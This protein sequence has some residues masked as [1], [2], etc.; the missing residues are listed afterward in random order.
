MGTPVQPDP[1]PVCGSDCDVCTPDPLASG[2]TPTSI[3]A[4]FHDV[5]P[6][7]PAH[8][9]PNDI[10][11]SL[12][13]SEPAPCIWQGDLNFGGC[14]WRAQYHAL[15]QLFWLLDTTC[16]TVPHFTTTAP[17]CTPG[18]HFNTQICGVAPGTGGRGYLLGFPHWLPTYLAL[19]LNLNPD[20]L[21]LYDLSNSATQDEIICRL[22]G[23]TSPGSVLIRLNTTDLPP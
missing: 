15:L 5:T 23:R 22:A 19:E 13:N 12:D 4:V 6:C 20:Q 7:P 10:P 3:K 8:T 21:A 2:S 9:P 17:Y 11:F 16:E 14:V 1:P 18:P